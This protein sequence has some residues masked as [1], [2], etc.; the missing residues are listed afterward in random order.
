MSQIERRGAEEDVA[1]APT[2]AG[3]T[4]D[5]R[6][7]MFG[8]SGSG[9]TSGYGGLVHPVQLPGGSSRPYGS[10]FDEVADALERAGPPVSRA[11]GAGGAARAGASA[12]AS[13]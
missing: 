6:R 2:A 5:V 13:Q 9:D 8:A 3:E 4:V 1:H 7:G 11:S 10:Y 12:P